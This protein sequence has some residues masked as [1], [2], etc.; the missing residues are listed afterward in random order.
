[1]WSGMHENSDN[2]IVEEIILNC[3][4]MNFYNIR[5]LETTRIRLSRVPQL[6]PY[7]LPAFLM[8]LNKTRRALY[9]HPP[10]IPATPL[11][12]H[13][14]PPVSPVS[15]LSLLSLHLS[16]S[17]I[18]KIAHLPRKLIVRLNFSDCC[19]TFSYA[20]R[21]LVFTP[22]HRAALMNTQRTQ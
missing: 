12:S 13:L 3:I 21:V 9:Y 20:R 1:M 17:P 5:T 19:L 15:F 6:V 22:S 16:L 10:C 14:S 8:P 11:P 4:E 7:R 2:Q 18:N